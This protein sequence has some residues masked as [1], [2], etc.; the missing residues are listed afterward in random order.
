[1]STDRF[2]TSLLTEKSPVSLHGKYCR[3]LRG[4]VG[5]IHER[6]YNEKIPPD[7]VVRVTEQRG[8]EC[9][10]EYNEAFFRV[11]DDNLEVLSD[12]ELLARGWTAEQ[13]ALRSLRRPY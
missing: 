9:S 7:S 2:P 5:G 8:R 6:D 1:M 12:A 3:T 13:L 11:A 4:V 10:V